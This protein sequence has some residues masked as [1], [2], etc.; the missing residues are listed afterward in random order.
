[1]KI[2]E[3]CWLC[4]SVV[5]V[6]VGSLFWVSQA[7]SMTPE[8]EL[9]IRAGQLHN[10]RHHMRKLETTPVFGW[11]MIQD[12]FRYF[13]L[14]RSERILRTKVTHLHAVIHEPFEAT[15]YVFGSRAGEAN[16]VMGCETGGKYNISAH[17]GQYLGLFQMGS[18]ERAKYAHGRY[19]TALDQVRAAFRY[20]LASRGWGP[21]QCKP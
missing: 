21:W 9:P 1:M 15:K 8:R 12:Q 16:N 6:V 20:F 19:R 10:V 3:K 4:F 14:L 18:S 17:N 13:N 2:S 7:K 11:T 5:L